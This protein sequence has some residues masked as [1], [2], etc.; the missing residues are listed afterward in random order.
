MQAR[1]RQQEEEQEREREKERS[2]LQ[3]Y[4][5]RKI[6]TTWASTGC[7]VCFAIEKFL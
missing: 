7:A 6:K 4:A 5:K 3:G 1:Q 2:K